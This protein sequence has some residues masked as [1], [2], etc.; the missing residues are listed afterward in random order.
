MKFVLAL[1]LFF[2]VAV[3]AQSDFVPG[4]EDLPLMEKMVIDEN[5]T[6]SFDTPA[7]QILN[8]TAKTPVSSQKVLS[9]YANTLPALGWQKKSGNSYKRDRD[10]IV[11]QTQSSQ[12][13]TSVLFQVTTPNN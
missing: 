11:I 13:G 2:S 1:C 6:I 8:V 12:T 10:E 5:E 4:T 7:G 9:F 3:Y